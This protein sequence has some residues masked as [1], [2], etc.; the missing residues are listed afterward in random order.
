LTTTPNSGEGGWS[1][2]DRT[3]LGQ[4]QRQA[5]RLCGA[6]NRVP[7]L[8][9][10][11]LGSDATRVRTRDTARPGRE[12]RFLSGASRW[13][14]GGSCAGFARKCSAS[15]PSCSADAS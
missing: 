4:S 3:A 13:G 12:D 2:T 8:S 10:N 1:M 9:R 7:G 6:A 15:V 11:G 5:E 14:G